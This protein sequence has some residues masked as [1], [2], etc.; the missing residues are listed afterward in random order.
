MY[1]VDHRIS[2]FIIAVEAALFPAVIVG[3]YTLSRSAL[4]RMSHSLVA[5]PSYSS[6]AAHPFKQ[7]LNITLSTLVAAWT[8]VVFS[9]YAA[10]G[11]SHFLSQRRGITM[12]RVFTNV[13]ETLFA[14][15]WPLIFIWNCASFAVQ[16][17][18][19][20]EGREQLIWLSL[21]IVLE[22]G[23][24]ALTF[25]VLMVYHN[26]TSKLPSI[27]GR[28]KARLADEIALL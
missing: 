20:V 10:L 6:A 7:T 21:I 13:V 16:F 15:Y 18:N 28:D 25:K 9:T 23:Y 5:T 27:L 14:L 22:N 12:S 26:S 17:N 2:S 11:S 8:T 24:V 4:L 1:L 3:R 19:H